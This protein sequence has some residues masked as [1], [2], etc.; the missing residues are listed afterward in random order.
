MLPYLEMLPNDLSLVHM[1]VLN[2]SRFTLKKITTVIID[3]NF[4]L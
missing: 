4:V 1:E 3:E 2:G